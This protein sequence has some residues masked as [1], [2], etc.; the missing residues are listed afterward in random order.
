MNRMDVLLKTQFSSFSIEDKLE[1]KSLVRINLGTLNFS[2]VA[3]IKIC[4]SPL[5]GLIRKMVDC[6]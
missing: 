5:F 4:N 3:R 2:R 6:K 1:I